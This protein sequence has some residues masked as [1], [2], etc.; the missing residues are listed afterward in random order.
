MKTARLVGITAVF[1]FFLCAYTPFPNL[2]YR[3]MAVPANVQPADAVVV[4]GAGITR[5]DRLTRASFERTIAALRLYR[6]GLAPRVFFLGIDPGGGK[7][8]ESEVRRQLALELGAE[9]RGIL[10]SPRG[11]TT[12]DE[13][14]LTR[15]QLAPLGVQRI[16][17]VTNATHMH[18]A[19]ILLEGSG[20]EV[21]PAPTDEIYGEATS[22]TA[23]LKVTH[24]CAI[25]LGAR[26]Y[27]ALAG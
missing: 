17:L 6:R 20:F 5:G 16:L 18:R 12:R 27:N 23:R 4:L 9:S 15:E 8:T 25:E 13:V 3:W 24:H 7:Q 19:R 1:L 21:F 26:I 10:L 22:P 2:L 14:R 11:W